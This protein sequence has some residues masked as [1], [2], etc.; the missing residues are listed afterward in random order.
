[1]PLSEQE[2]RLLD[3]MER[4]LYH[5]DAD[6]VTTVGAR[7]GRPNYTAVVLGVLTGAIG[8]ILLVV[9]VI[10]RQ[11]IVGIIGFAIMFAGTL[12]A[13]APPRRLTLPSGGQNAAPA[14]PRTGFMD[15]LNERWERRN[16]EHDS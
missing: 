16:D 2:Q 1:M 3:E 8:L 13:I 5:N 10:I 12:V 4:S 11:P 14:K 9:G 6:D 15:S 7:R